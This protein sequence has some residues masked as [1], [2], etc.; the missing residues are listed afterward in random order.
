MPAISEAVQE[1]IERLVKTEGYE[2]VHMEFKYGSGRHFLRIFIDR[3]GGIT[4]DDCQKISHQLSTLLDVEDPIPQR[5][6]LEVSS[7]G[8]DRRLYKEADYIRFIGQRIRLTLSQPV[9]GRRSYRG[10]I[11][12]AGDGVV[13]VGEPGQGEWSFA[14]NT[15]EKANLEIEF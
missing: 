2:L 3:P 5:Y 13:Q 1:S 4:L 11:V 8:L 7:P 15:I 6:T 12:A 14:I 9:G 10:R